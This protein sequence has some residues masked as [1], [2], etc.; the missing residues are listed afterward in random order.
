MNHDESRTQSDKWDI[1]ESWLCHELNEKYREPMSHVWITMNHEL[2]E[3]HRR[4]KSHVHGTNPMTKIYVEDQRVMYKSR[5]SW[6]IYQINT[7]CACH[8]SIHHVHV[9]NS[10]DIGDPW[11]MDMSGT[12]LR[13]RDINESCV[14]QG[15]NEESM[16]SMSH[17][18]VTNSMSHVHVTN[19][20]TT[21]YVGDQRVMYRSTNP[22]KFYET[23]ESCTCHE[24]N[25][26][27][28]CRRS[29]SHLS[30][31]RKWL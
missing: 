7:S 8:R 21:I 12:H 13:I 3:E 6:G 25:A 5:I 22:W 2:N 24:L 19:S 10:I 27:N 31:T 9:T 11:L 16:R 23:N 1:N 18:H 26:D 15:S 28:I 20:M 17:V 29:T 4:S 14:S 30:F